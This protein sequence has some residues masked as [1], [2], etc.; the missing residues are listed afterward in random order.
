MAKLDLSTHKTWIHSSIQLVLKIF[1]S[2][3]H[4][5]STFVLETSHIGMNKADKTYALNRIYIYK[6]SN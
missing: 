2:I 5:P 4:V 1:L 3:N 6:E